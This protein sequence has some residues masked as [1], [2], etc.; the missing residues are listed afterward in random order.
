MSVLEGTLTMEDELDWGG[1]YRI[2]E[3]LGKS[4]QQMANMCSDMR[5]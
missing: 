1:Q 5:Q 3:T 2:R 4:T